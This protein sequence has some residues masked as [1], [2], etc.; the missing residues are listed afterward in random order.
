MNN[1]QKDY[2]GLK[3]KIENLPFGVDYPQI[4]TLLRRGDAWE[5]S[6]DL[7]FGIDAREEVLKHLKSGL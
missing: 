7:V 1:G 4:F 6:P 2:T 5:L 3:S